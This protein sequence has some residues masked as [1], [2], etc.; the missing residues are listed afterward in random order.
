M[1]FYLSFLTLTVIFSIGSGAEQFTDLATDDVCP[2][3]R[4]NARTVIED[5]LTGSSWT[6]ERQ[7]LG[8]SVDAD[9]IRV[10]N[11]SQDSSSC[12]KLAEMF[13]EVEQKDRMFY[14]AGSYHFVIYKWTERSDGTMAIGSPGF[15]ILND[16]FD[17]L[18][19]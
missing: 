2:R 13:P 9:Q 14:K 18:C 5:F 12:Q 8:V 19:F 1:F 7:E 16:D 10:L 15:I 3:A 6:D 17:V 11:N 4:E